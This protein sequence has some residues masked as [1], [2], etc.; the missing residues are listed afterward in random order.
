[1]TPYPNSL[2]ATVAVIAVVGCSSA[3]KQKI[4]STLPAPRT[5]AAKVQ[6]VTAGSVQET[7]VQKFGRLTRGV[8]G[9]SIYFAYDDFTIQPKYQQSIQTHAAVL[10]QVD[11][12]TVIL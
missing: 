1:M 3:P 5:P 4:V 6:S 8:E 2:L 12:G 10:T 11:R 7:E 9:Q